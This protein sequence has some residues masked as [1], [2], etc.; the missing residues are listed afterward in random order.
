MLHDKP[1]LDTSNTKQKVVISRPTPNP[2]LDPITAIDTPS[3]HA[4]ASGNGNDIYEFV[5][6]WHI[7]LPRRVRGIKINIY[8]LFWKRIMRMEDKKIVWVITIT[9]IKIASQKN[10][11]KNQNTANDMFCSS[12]G[13]KL[14]SQST[15]D[16]N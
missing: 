7:I 12:C 2:F 3:N 8:H 16:M 11:L 5:S 4:S 6:S 10:K 15:F 13:F 1:C 9:I 14:N